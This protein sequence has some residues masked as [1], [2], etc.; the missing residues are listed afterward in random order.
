MDAPRTQRRQS[1]PPRWG[2]SRWGR[3]IAPYPQCIG[4][5]ARCAARFSARWRR[6]CIADV[7]DASPMLRCC[8]ADVSP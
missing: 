2:P 5:A 3:R 4:D 1:R 6:R 7:A 8:I